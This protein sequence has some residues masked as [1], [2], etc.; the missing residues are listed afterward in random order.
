[1][2]ASDRLQAPPTTDDVPDA[3]LGAF[4]DMLAGT[5]VIWK[6][7]KFTSDAVNTPLMLPA[8]WLKSLQSPPLLMWMSVD[9]PGWWSWVWCGRCAR[10]TLSME[11]ATSSHTAHLS[12]PLESQ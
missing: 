3:G 8:P 5:V 7:P 12:S 1:M 2:P 11:S 10:R 9:G 4:G 6:W